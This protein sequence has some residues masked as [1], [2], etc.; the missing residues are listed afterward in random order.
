[1]ADGASVIA[2]GA[3]ARETTGTNSATSGLSAL[4]T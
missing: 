2:S 3:C 4:V 1:M